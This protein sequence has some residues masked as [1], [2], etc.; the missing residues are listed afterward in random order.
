[1][2]LLHVQ[3]EM[4]ADRAV[5]SLAGELDLDSVDELRAPTEDAVRNG[6]GVVVLDMS[7]LSFIDS[8]GLALLVELRRMA[9]EAGGELSI[10]NLPAALR[11]VV[12]IAGLTETLGL[13]PP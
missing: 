10:V 7:E 2:A 1:M 6:P 13:P 4:G 5:L 11:R 12:T 9:S 3:V 8:S